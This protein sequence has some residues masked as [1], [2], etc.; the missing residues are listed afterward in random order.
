MIFVPIFRKSLILRFILHSLAH[1]WLCNKIFRK[2]LKIQ[3]PGPYSKFLLNQ[4]IWKCGQGV[5]TLICR[6]FWTARFGLTQWKNWHLAWKS[7]TPNST[8]NAIYDIILENGQVIWTPT[9]SSTKHL[10]NKIISVSFSNNVYY[11][12]SDPFS[13]SKESCDMN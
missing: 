11:F 6:W 4:H 5:C 1:S 2:L 10:Q 7:E 13:Y 8:L 3:I 12:T 9:A